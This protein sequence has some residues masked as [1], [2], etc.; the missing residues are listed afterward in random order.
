MAAAPQSNN[1][2]PGVLKCGYSGPNGEPGPGH[3]PRRLADQGEDPP[4]PGVPPLEARRGALKGG[5]T[6]TGGVPGPRVVLAKIFQSV[7][8]V[9]GAKAPL[10][11]IFQSMGVVPGVRSFLAAA[12][13][14]NNARPG[15]LKCGYSGPNGE[16]GPG[17]SPPEASGG[18]WQGR[19]RVRSPGRG[20][21][22]VSPRPRLAPGVPACEPQARPGCQ[23]PCL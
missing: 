7:V 10:A 1:A 13:Q 19:T 23:G 8:V 21:L 6:G 3:S 12:P 2:R 5:R 17:Q 22:P 15:V 18:P 16:P 14:S 9:P 4:R 11:K 20:S